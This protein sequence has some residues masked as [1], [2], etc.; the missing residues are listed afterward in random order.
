MEG[1]RNIER[2][3]ARWTVPATDTGLATAGTNTTLTD[4]LKDWP[5]NR[6]T[7]GQVHIIKANGAEYLRDILGNTATQLTFNP[8]PG[9]ITVAAGDIY[10]VSDPKVFSL[11]AIDLWSDPLSIFQIG[12]TPTTQPLPTITIADIPSGATLIRTAMMLKFRALSED[13]GSDN[14]LSGA[15]VMQA[16]KDIGGAWVTGVNLVDGQMV[17][18]ASLRDS[19]DVVIGSIDIKAQVPANG[20][21]MDFQWLDS[22]ALGDSLYLEDLQVGLRIWYSL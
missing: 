15:Q 3:L 1:I 9:G 2:A 19:G 16:K 8:L 21:D 10:T 4:A 17:C 22:L 7:R 18:L 20:A 11:Q 14:S 6:W 5:V 12:T 13:S